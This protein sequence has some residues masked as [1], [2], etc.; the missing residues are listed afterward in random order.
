MG[1]SIYDTK[2]AGRVKQIGEKP[3]IA[4]KQD[5]KKM[6]ADFQKTLTEAKDKLNAMIM[7][8]MSSDHAME[9]QIEIISNLESTIKGM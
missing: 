9:K 7:F 4:G 8:K 2:R 1:S 5:K 6:K 3:D